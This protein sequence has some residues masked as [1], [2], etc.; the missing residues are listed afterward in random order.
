MTNELDYVR[1][2]L[3]SSE[4][5]KDELSQSLQVCTQGGR[6]EGGQVLGSR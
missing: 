5:Y 4:Q 3:A 1:A 2:E 6:K